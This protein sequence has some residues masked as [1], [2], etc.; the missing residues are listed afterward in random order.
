M[1]KPIK[2]SKADALIIANIQIDFLPGGAL[3]VL[4]GDSVIPVI[5][6]Y[7]KIFRRAGASI[8]AVRDWHPQNHVSFTGQGGQWP[9]HC[10]QESEG[11]K[12]HPDLKLP[13]GTVI[14]SKATDTLND[15]YSSFDG[16]ELAQNLEMQ[17]IYRLFVGGL[18]TE[19]CI[20]NTV[21]DSRKLGFGTL[22]LSDAVRG[23]NAK[24]NDTNRAIEEMVS[25]GAD[26]V[27]LE[28][29][30]DALDVPF[31]EKPRSDI[32]SE[33]PVSKVELKR[34]ARMRP[35]GPYKKVR[36]ERG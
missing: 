35:R 34:K 29:F 16:T 7:L 24:P 28:D 20:L 4:E 14:I 26:Q 12:F 9:P 17:G 13:E 36:T 22:L 33:K 11:A 10:I 32:I 23:I 8:F 30:P 19:Y 2:I 21:L 27:T 18:A 6:D 31:D 25:T 1:K 3:P 5:N 15:S